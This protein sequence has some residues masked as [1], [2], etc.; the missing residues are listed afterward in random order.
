MTRCLSRECKAGLDPVGG[1]IGGFG[2]LE[3]RHGRE[4]DAPLEETGSQF[5]A[6][7]TGGTS[8]TQQHQHLLSELP[9]H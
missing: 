3:G 6:R 4:R 7:T 2:Q 8:T 9:A 1:G 5:V